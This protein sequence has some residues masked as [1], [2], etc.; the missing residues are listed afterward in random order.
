MTREEEIRNA[1]DTIIPIL[2][3]ENGRTYEQALMATGF[4]KGAQ[5]ADKHP[6]NPWI[7]VKDDLP[8]NHAEML[9]PMCNIKTQS[10]ITSIRGLCYIN[11]MLKYRDKWIW[12]MGKPTHWMPIPKLPKE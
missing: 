11:N 10:V 5:W 9:H 4:E 12:E 7:S 3:S 6:K 2:P 8:C 1:I